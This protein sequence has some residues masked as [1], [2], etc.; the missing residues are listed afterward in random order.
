MIVGVSNPASAQL[1]KPVQWTNTV[2]VLVDGNNLKKNHELKDW[3]AGAV[4]VNTIT[5]GNAYIE[6]TITDSTKFVMIGFSKGDTDQ[7]WKD[8]D[9]PIQIM[10]NSKLTIYQVGNSVSFPR[11][12]YLIGDILRIEINGSDLE[13]K[14][15]G[16][17]IHILEG[18]IDESDYP[19]SVDTSMRFNGTTLNDVKIGIISEDPI[20]K[21]Q[22]QIEDMVVLL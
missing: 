11:D 4:S 14:I 19:L 16:E 5:S 17:T 13:Y 8:I 10:N 22:I 9:F 21:L 3:N 1:S 7:F 6:T 20:E 15:N 2:N 12:T 18:V